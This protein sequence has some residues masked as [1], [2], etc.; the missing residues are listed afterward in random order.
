MKTFIE[1]YINSAL[2][3]IGE[4]LNV[5]NLAPETLMSFVRDC[6]D[7]KRKHWDIIKHDL[8]DAGRTFWEHRNH[9]ARGFLNGNWRPGVCELLA[10]EANSYMPVKLF[11]GTDKKIHNL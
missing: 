4:N 11:I 9:L 3:A 1:G 2:K 7:F 8:E 5:S 10:R 6:N